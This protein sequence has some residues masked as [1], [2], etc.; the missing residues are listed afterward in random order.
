MLMTAVVVMV[1]ITEASLELARITKNCHSMRKLT[2]PSSKHTNTSSFLPST[3]CRIGEN[4][5]WDSAGI[6]TLTNRTEYSI[7]K[8]QPFTVYSFRV[9]A[10]N[11]IGASPPSKESYYTVTNRESK[12]ISSVP[13]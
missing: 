1:M 8:L 7:D 13:N 11:A 10:V 3:S 12:C 6:A 9:I 4:G 5:D 2:Q